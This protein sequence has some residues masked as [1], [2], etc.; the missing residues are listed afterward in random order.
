MRASMRLGVVGVGG[1]GHSETFMSS[2]CV[3][4]CEESGQG[5][6]EER[7]EERCMER[8]KG[9]SCRSGFIYRSVVKRSHLRGMRPFLR[10]D[11]RGACLKSKR[12]L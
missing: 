6:G 11:R 9:E 10:C 3:C 4:V 2:M 8:E 5:E 1:G 7:Q 12:Q